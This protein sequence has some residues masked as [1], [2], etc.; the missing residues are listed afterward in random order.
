LS[1]PILAR[2]VDALLSCVRKVPGVRSVENHLA[3]CREAGNV[4]SLQGGQPREGH[5]FELFQEN[6]S[7]TARLLT[8]LAGGALVL[9]AIRRPGAPAFVLAAAGLGLLARSATNRR[10][11]SFVGAD[12][13]RGIEV[14]KTLSIKALPEDVFAFWTNYENFPRCM[15][16]VLEVRPL[17]GNRSHWV[18]RGPA[19]TPIEWTSEMTAVVPERLI[20]WRSV[21]GSMVKHWGTVRFDPSELGGTRVSIR[22]CYVPVAGAIG[23]A[24]AKLFGSDPKSEMDADLMRMKSTI[25][26]GH[27]PHDAAA[28]A[29]GDRSRVLNEAPAV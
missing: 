8:F 13:D 23:H 9:G 15:T 29:A 22:F 3:V 16:H 20:E 2:E 4:S 7:P 14:Q 21:E 12:G 17:E 19:G 24:V 25:E 5:R 1:G 18:V 27:P 26:T 11:A 28:S 6:W 10:I